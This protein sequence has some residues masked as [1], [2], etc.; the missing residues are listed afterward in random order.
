L[1][2]TRGGF[3]AVELGGSHPGLAERADG[4]ALFASSLAGTAASG[5]A[6]LEDEAELLE[7]A[8]RVESLP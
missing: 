6:S 5:L 7:L 8:W 2:P 4:T 1:S 3:T